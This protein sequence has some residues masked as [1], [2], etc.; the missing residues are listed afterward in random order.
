MVDNKDSTDGRWYR[1][2]WYR[3]LTVQI[4]ASTDGRLY[5]GRRDFDFFKNLHLAHLKMDSGLKSMTKIE[6]AFF[7]ILSSFRS[8]LVFLEKNLPKSLNKV[9]YFFSQNMTLWV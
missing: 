5:R 8:S 4:I 1:G 3:W 2:K 6:K 9:Q 7:I